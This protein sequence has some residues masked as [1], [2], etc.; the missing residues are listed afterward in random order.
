MGVGL[1]SQALAGLQVEAPGLGGVDDLPVEGGINHDGDRSVVLRGRTHHRRTADVDLLD[2]VV[3][4]G[5]GG[6]GLHERVQVDDHQVDRVNV[7]GGQGVHVLAH[8]AVG[9][10]AAVDPRVQRLHAPVQHFRGTGNLFHLGDGDAGRGDA[11]GR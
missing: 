8:A 11:L 6:D 1:G 10:D 4:R 9:Q 7:H 3:L 2:H 5:A